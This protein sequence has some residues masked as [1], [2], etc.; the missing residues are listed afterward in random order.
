MLSFDTNIAVHAANTSSPLHASA[1]DFIGSLAQRNDVAISELMLVELYLK[2]R[3]AKIFPRPLGPAQA[4]ASCEV[5]RANRAW[6]R[7]EAAPVMDDV[8][9][10]AG[11]RGFAIRRIIDVR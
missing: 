2:L 10:L 1:Y 5:Y 11:R 7:V 6:M 3:N 8:W 9:R 4:A